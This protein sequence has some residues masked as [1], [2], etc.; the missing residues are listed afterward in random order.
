MHN[1]PTLL[2]FHKCQTPLK[3][4]SQFPTLKVTEK[5]RILSKSRTPRAQT[6]MEVLKNTDHGRA[7]K[8]AILKRKLKLSR[9]LSAGKKDLD[10]NGHHF[11]T[12]E[13]FNK[14]LFE[15]CSQETP[16]LRR[17]LMKKYY[18]SVTEENALKTPKLE[19]EKI[20]K[21]VLDEIG[22][23]KDLD[24]EQTVLELNL[25]KVATHGGFKFCILLIDD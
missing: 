4:N 20:K 21:H 19:E 1:Y 2:K 14:K 17:T 25:K 13:A 18:N 11:L 15:L 8:R 6:Q 22:I 9:K 23:V 3:N 5:K 16:D 12:N 10:K 7:Y 24:D